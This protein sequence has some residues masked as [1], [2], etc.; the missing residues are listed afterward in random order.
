MVK[1]VQL[2]FRRILLLRLLL[3]SVP[4]LLMGVYATFAFTYRKTR[5]ALLETARQ[6]LTES[7]VRK[8][9][10]LN[11]TIEALKTNLVVASGSLI[12]AEGT[13][14][15][16]NLYIRQL[17]STLPAQTQCIQLAI[18]RTQ[19]AIASTCA[20]QPLS[21]IDVRQWSPTRKRLLLEASQVSFQ[22]LVPE[23]GTATHRDDLPPD[24]SVL[25]VL[26]SAP[27]YDTDG[28][29]AYILSVKSA[30]L[31][32]SELRPRSLAGYSVAIDEE[33][34]ILM[35]PSPERAG[36]KIQKEQS[37]DRWQSLLKKAIEGRQDFFHLFVENGQELLAGY[38]AI[39]SPV[40]TEPDRQ[41]AIVAVTPLDNA[42]SGLSEIQKTLSS[43]LLFLT[44]ALLSA[45]I[46]ATLYVAR[47]LARPLEKL[48][49]Y[50]LNEDN[51]HSTEQIPQNFQI[52]EFNQLTSALNGM[53]SRLRTWAKELTT[54]WEEAQTA[55]RLK[56]EFLTTI[57][58]ELRT[59]LNGI[60]GSIRLISDGFCDDR[61]E[62]MEFLQ[63]ADDAAV[64]LLGIIN[65]ILDISKIEAGQHS[66][67]VESVDLGKIFN[68]VMALQTVAIR[69]KGLG[70]RIPEWHE[71]IMVYADPA[72]LKQVLLNV[73]DNAIKFTKAGE[74]SVSLRSEAIP[75]EA[76][77]SSDT[78]QKQEPLPPGKIHKSDRQVVL[79]I[80]DTGI[81]LDPDDMD[82]IFRPFVMVDGSTTRE[83]G[84][85]GLGLA[86]SRNFMELMGGSI[87]L[88][89]PGKDLG[90]TVEISL[91]LVQVRPSLSPTRS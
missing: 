46:L 24:T 77:E 61:D 70:Y 76:L 65:D 52:R 5:S 44:V 14:E 79:T 81:G 78:L 90:T 19:E 59:P 62:E 56:S 22:V 64:H 39:P 35:H 25:H 8:A 45:S 12:L 63:K 20:P 55:N 36:R 89:S 23:P 57:S 16:R 33:G 42:L 27:V 40:S 34:T 69:E 9:A 3:V 87:T 2:S 50:A 85:T 60:I 43:L 73:L 38:T 82:K 28:Q 17:G 51:L 58:H 67:A 91:P 18:A 31:E 75:E 74:I 80:S 21:Q 83:S 49:D 86:I 26:L 10:K 6:N 7:A 47:D 54:A 1:P 88:S 30:L 53:V 84:G 71:E 11:Q 37:A 4:V 68:E 15:E 48:R 72:K 66:I 29:L 13:P 41:W 32:R